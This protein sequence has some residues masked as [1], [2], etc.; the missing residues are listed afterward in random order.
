MPDRLFSIRNSWIMGILLIA[1]NV[2][3]LLLTNLF[4]IA[5]GIHRDR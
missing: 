1:L 5:H 4:G 2:G 3:I